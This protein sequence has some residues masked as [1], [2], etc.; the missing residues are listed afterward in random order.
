MGETLWQGAGALGKFIPGQQI[1]EGLFSF[2]GEAT[3]HEV[4]DI[5]EKDSPVA[6]AL[7]TETT[8]FDWDLEDYAVCM[9]VAWGR[10]GSAENDVTHKFLIWLDDSSLTRAGVALILAH[11]CPKIFHY[12]DFDISFIREWLGVLD[13][14]P[15]N[16]TI[17]DTVL[18]SY[19][20]NE[21]ISKRLKDRCE[22][23]FGKD[24]KK[25]QGDLKGWMSR[26]GVKRYSDV[27]KDILGPYAMGDAILT[28]RL[29]WYL[30]EQVYNDP[31]L[32]RVYEFERRFMRT[33]IEMV[34]R[35]FKFD[36]PFVAK[37]AKAYEDRIT[38]D[39]LDL[40]SEG[41]PDWVNPNADAVLGNYLVHNLG[42]KLP[43][44]EKGKQY[45]TSVKTFAR[46][47][48]PLVIALSR[49]SRDTK[50]LSTYTDG[51]LA[52]IGKDG[53]IHTRIRQVEAT[54]GRM[55]S[56][57]PNLQNVPRN[58]PVRKAFI[59]SKG[60]ILMFADYSQ[61]EARLFAAYAKDLDML[62]VIDEGGDLH[63]LNATKIFQITS[64]DVPPD[65][66]KEMRQLA[67][68]ANFSIMYGGG[69]DTLEN[70]LRTEPVGETA[71]G[72]DRY[73][74]NDEACEIYYKLTG[75][76]MYGDPIRLLA[77]A[78]L[79]TYHRE[80][81]SV[82]RFSNS[83]GVRIKSRGYVTTLMGR[84]RRLTSDE[85][86]KAGNSVIQ[87]SAA[88]LIKWAMIRVDD[89]LKEEKL[90]AKMVLVVHDEII[91]DL[92]EREVLVLSKE[93]PRLMTD[94]KP[95][96]TKVPIQV[97]I[98]FSRESWYKNDKRPISEFMAIN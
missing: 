25:L 94:Y 39:K 33:V 38:Q 91:F 47:E 68:K 69:A 12:A 44:T 30:W 92:P 66:W 7:D 24:T 58:A 54:T 2:E 28:W 76:E 51:Y 78:L 57:R 36:A 49:Y 53:R 98:Q 52:R 42:I 65:V 4:L 56:A 95:I 3:A 72:R 97:D 20:V 89:F 71:D 13:P 19:V 11:P 35:G 31:E 88:D 74:T 50:I 43:L 1:F 85:V 90:A 87:G 10:K 9:T 60:N 79:E 32:L 62:R 61:V 82:R 75:K 29:F 17:E 37:M 8:G 26:N 15:L 40:K 22:M 80:I 21:N 23:Y 55:S 67:K 96:T 81:P 14:I 84:R 86:Y 46:I 48:H 64:A 5:M 27:P 18:L 59:P 70:T 93:L 45:S 73:L 16:G 41:L 77:E 83:C 6:I 34:A 63:G